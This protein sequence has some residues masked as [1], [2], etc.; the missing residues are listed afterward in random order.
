VEEAMRIIQEGSTQ[1]NVEEDAIHFIQ[2]TDPNSKSKLKEE[3]K[4]QSP[5]PELKPCLRV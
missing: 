1:P 5:L 3:E 4:S 2:E